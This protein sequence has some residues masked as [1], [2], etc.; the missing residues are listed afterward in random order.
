MTS[1]V[2]GSD[3]GLVQVNVGGAGTA[4]GLTR[5]PGNVDGVVV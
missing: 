5:L 2:D 3:P 1:E 4:E